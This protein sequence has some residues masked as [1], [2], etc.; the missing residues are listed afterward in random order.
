MSLFRFL[1]ALVILSASGAASGLVALGIHDAVHASTP[2]VYRYF[3]PSAGYAASAGDYLQWSIRNGRAL[4]VEEILGR[5]PG[6]P[7]ASYNLFH[8]TFTVAA[9]G[10]LPSNIAANGVD[11]V[12][13]SS[14]G[15]LV[16]CVTHQM[17]DRPRCLSW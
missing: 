11:R 7:P 6:G 8:R 15:G 4:G 9:S 5:S 14:T 1:P 13:F 16:D 3:Q 12:H 17:A 2:A 10:N